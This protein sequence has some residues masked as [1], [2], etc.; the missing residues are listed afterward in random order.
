VASEPVQRMMPLVETQFDPAIEAKG[1]DKMRSIIE[2]ELRDG[3]SFVQPSD[4]RYRG[5]PEKPFTREELHE[6]FTDCASL[7]LSKERI[8]K[9]LQL[10]EGVD[11][12]QNVREL[13]AGLA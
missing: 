5:G 4:E 8:A 12:L 10:I 13:V 1:F 3:R 9:A 6:K 11:K 2:V 7:V